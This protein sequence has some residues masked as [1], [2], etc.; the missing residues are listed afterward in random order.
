[1]R[2]V[3][4][5]A[6]ADSR[7]AMR[8]EEFELKT[9]RCGVATALVLALAVGACGRAPETS[10]EAGAGPV[11]SAAQ[12]YQILDVNPVCPATCNAATG[13]FTYLDGST[14]RS[15]SYDVVDGSQG[16]AGTL[17]IDLFGT[18]QVLPVQEVVIGPASL[19][20]DAQVVLGGEPGT[21]VVDFFF[22][23]SEFPE[24]FYFFRIAERF[25]TH[26]GYTNTFRPGSC[27][28]VGPG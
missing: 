5:F 14:P 22:G 11:R 25:P 20:I 13:R 19:R 18:T 15:V 17:T 4:T 7:R 21:I 28:V 27:E 6:A 10:A 23:N 16:D 12:R 1:M 9:P 2:S 3:G 24:G 26:S 8:E